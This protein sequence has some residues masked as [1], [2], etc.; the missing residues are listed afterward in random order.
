MMFE[1][2]I[3]SPVGELR[4]VASDD[5]L[6]GVFFE[7]HTPAPAIVARRLDTHPILVAAA[8]QLAE[9]FTGERRTF[10]LRLAPQGT[11]VQR[12][13]WLALATIPFGTTTSYAALASAIR[14]PGSARAIGHANARNPL[15]I[16]LPCHRVVATTGALT[17]YAGGLDRK[18]WLLAHEGSRPPS[19]AATPAASS[20]SAGYV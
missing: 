3:Q 14:R 16:V 20:S 13:V 12:E 19:V 9:Y 7:G 8:R 1:T 11:A 10:D 6:V 4:L 5:A 18:R 17:G 15:S 2:H